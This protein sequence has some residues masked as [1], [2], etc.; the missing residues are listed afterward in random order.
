MGLARETAVSGG[1][2]ET[3]K[4]I[5]PGVPITVPYGMVLTVFVPSTQTVTDIGYE[6]LDTFATGDA[7]FTLVDTYT[8]A[9]QFSDVTMWIFHKTADPATEANW[10]YKIHYTPGVTFTNP[11]SAFP[12]VAVLANFEGVDVAVAP[13]VQAVGFAG[14]GSGTALTLPSVSADQAED[15]YTI[16][17]S[18]TD[19]LVPQSPLI[20]QLNLG[21]SFP[22]RTGYQSFAPG[23]LSGVSGTRTHSG[24]TVAGAFGAIMLI[25][26]SAPGGGWGVGMVRMGAN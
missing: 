10:T 15:L 8:H 11:L 22:I 19:R 23:G 18:W 2:S 17:H 5:S 20:P 25:G 4:T 24:S 16:V 21:G 7:G 12:L 14:M 9:G 1:F 26:H 6:D 3:V 13:E